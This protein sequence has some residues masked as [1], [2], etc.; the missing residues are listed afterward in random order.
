MTQRQ[1]AERSCN[2]ECPTEA[3][4]EAN[5]TNIDE[6]LCVAAAAIATAGV[7][8]IREWMES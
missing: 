2:D 1:H 3:E 6:A 4:K 5:D 7:E 8:V